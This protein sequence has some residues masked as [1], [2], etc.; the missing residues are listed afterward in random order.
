[1]EDKKECGCE[2]F[3][4]RKRNLL[5]NFEIGKYAEIQD[6]LKTHNEKY[7]SIMDVE[8]T[9][10]FTKTF[11]FKRADDYANVIAKR[12]MANRIM[13]NI[14]D[15]TT[16]YVTKIN[17][18]QHDYVVSRGDSNLYITPL[19][20]VNRNEKDRNMRLNKVKFAVMDEGYDE[21]TDYFRV[22][23]ATH[24]LNHRI[25]GNH[26]VFEDMQTG[27]DKVEIVFEH[28][29]RSHK[30]VY[31]DGKNDGLFLNRKPERLADAMTEDA[32]KMQTQTT[33]LMSIG[34]L[35]LATTAVGYMVFSRRK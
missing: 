2:G 13:K 29:K 6:L 1:M 19:K 3:Q 12:Y 16:Y 21:N 9:S 31:Y 34:L 33:S 15:E 17:R 7:D 14:D 27:I 24:V 22:K 10:E 35:T 8:K 26:I 11:Y 23:S 20:P 4:N 18:D 32:T 28:M 30:P 5:E 25:V